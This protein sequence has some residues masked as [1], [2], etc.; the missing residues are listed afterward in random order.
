[1]CPHSDSR[2]AKAEGHMSQ[3]TFET[4]LHQLS[5]VRL[6]KVC[7]Y[8]Q[9]EPFADPDLVGRVVRALDVLKSFSHIELSTNC[10]LMTPERLEDLIVSMDGRKRLDVLL[11]LPG[12][13]SHEHERITGLNHATCLEHLKHFLVRTDKVQWITRQVQ[14]CGVTGF[15]DRFFD[16]L[17]LSRKPVLSRFPPISRAGNVVRDQRVS[18]VRGADAFRRCP[19]LTHWFHIDWEGNL[20]ACCHDYHGE[21][22]LGS[23]LEE[24]IQSLEARMLL[25][26]A[27][28]SSKGNF[29][30]TRC[31]TGG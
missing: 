22:V 25:R 6:G 2:L 3:L 1:M 8:L 14:L 7:M 28:M 29:L 19:R 4:V 20:I 21:A 27:A 26:M 16:D 13:T 31:E 5:R 30:C 15:E 9:N 11:S 10:S 23:L 18:H 17:G 24:D 12:A